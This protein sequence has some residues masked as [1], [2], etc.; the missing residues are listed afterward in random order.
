[1]PTGG[2]TAYK[3]SKFASFR[4]R[5][6]GM[7]MEASYTS[8]IGVLLALT[9]PASEQMRTLDTSEPTEL[10]IAARA[11]VDRNGGSW[12]F[13][14]DMRTER[15]G[16][17]QGSGVPLI[18]GAG[19]DLEWPEGDL[20]QAGPTPFTIDAI[21]PRV[22][23]F[24]AGQRALIGPFR[25]RLTLD[26]GASQIRE[27]GRVISV[28][29][30]WIV[31]GVPVEG[32]TVFAR[33]NSGNVTQF[34][35]RRIG[36][37]DT[38]TTPVLDATDAL[39]AL[40]EVSNDA[41]RARPVGE[42]ELWLQPED[43]GD[44]LHFR[45][46]WKLRYSVFG[47]IETWEGRVDAMTG[48]VVGFRDTNIYAKAVGGV[49]PRSVFFRNE[50]RA[51][52]PFLE[53]RSS[54][55][56]VVTDAGGWY[57]YRGGPV[58][59]GLD[60]VNFK[61]NCVSCTAPQNASVQ[62]AFGIGRLD[63]GLGGRDEN[64]NGAS[65]P[66]ER[67]TFFHLTQVRRI[68]LKWLPGLEWLRNH[69]LE[70][71]VNIDETCNAFFDENVPSLNFF[72]SGDY[73]HNTGEIADIVHHEW[74][75]ALDL[76]TLL[77][78]RGT[79]EGTADVTAMHLT[80]SSQI[81][82]GFSVFGD[83]IRDLDAS[84]SPLG[85][86]TADRVDRGDC[87]LPLGG[88]S[89][90]CIGQVYGQTAWDLA[91][92]LTAG[93]GHH[94][95]WRASE[96][97]FFVSLPDAGTYL[98]DSAL[99]IYPAYL[100]ADDDDGDLSNGTP[101]AAQIHE[102]FERHGIARRPL[103]TS[104]PCVRPDQPSVTVEPI[105]G[106]FELSWAPVEGAAQYEILRGELLED[107]AYHSLAD[108][109]SRAA[110]YADTEVAEETDYWYVVMAV[111][112]D[113]CESTVEHPEHAR[114]AVRPILSVHDMTVSDRAAGNRSGFP[115]PGEEIE[116]QIAFAK[117][118]SEYGPWNR[119]RGDGRDSGPE[120]LPGMAGA[121]GRA[122]R[123]QPRPSA[124][125][126]RTGHALRRPVAPRV[127]SRGRRNRLRRF[128]VVVLRHSRRRDRRRRGIRLR[129]DAGLL[130][131][132]RI[133]RHRPHIAR[134]L[135]RGSPTVLASRGDAL[136]ERHDHLRRV[137]LGFDDVSTRRGNTRR[138][139][140][141]RNVVRRSDARTRTQVSLPGA[142]RGLPIRSRRQLDRARCLRSSL[143]GH[144][145]SGVFGDRNV[146]HRR[147]LR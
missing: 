98:P 80:H 126:S 12:T 99:A 53:L 87:D 91:Q 93:E 140:R 120:P 33:L 72:R 70:V 108:L 2:P 84:K 118:R 40:L 21:E 17:A 96:R 101:H 78:D 25:G 134:E 95:G 47:R 20:P 85:V 133:R 27:D 94:T 3:G 59:A 129:P 18:P 55:R 15:L 4:R 90:H 138:I 112:A 143:S 38:A 11:F 103:P 29:Y 74:G 88:V 123:R 132:A 13:I 10:G 137:P 5:V 104:A 8:L 89:V 119:T 31:D 52:L 26:R 127:D 135:L 100:Q 145:P 44:T 139:R 107:S 125:A 51:P 92:L 14:V 30:D 124:F 56:T 69:R 65:S 46:I 79:A 58:R 142:R 39:T 109:S 68:A 43:A 7:S 141:N 76:A 16:L 117:G 1:L 24:L 37:I 32:A 81:A 54:G 28:Y 71:N 60:S 83:P 144:R 128:G 130:R 115:D 36:R 66:A 105:C 9:L 131:S 42:P 34:G 136:R 77:L 110:S 113:G 23:R 63:F 116:L 97:L 121:R 146:Q 111:A 67:N 64:G 147:G 6:G 86:L 62:A 19:N 106:G 61:M 122:V 22:R 49:Y 75:H 48:E 45:L 82:P 35:S 102:A 57:P 73:C 50:V 114:N 41:E